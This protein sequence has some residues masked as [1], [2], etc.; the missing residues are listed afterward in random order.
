VSRRIVAWTLGWVVSWWGF[1]LLAG[2]WN[3]I[4]WIGGA[5]VA[6]VTAT[7]AVLVRAVAH[8]PLPVSLAPLRSAGSAFAQVFV[9]FGILMLALPR[10]RAGRYVARETDAPDSA[11]TVLVAGMS[12]NAY[13][14][15]LDPEAGTV[16]LHDLVPHRPSE[17]P[18]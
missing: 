3:H 16:L 12:P 14:V 4:E 18:A 11:L 15:D 9:D 8:V 6:T 2:D 7:L 5:A 17:R 10:R 1:Q 13:V